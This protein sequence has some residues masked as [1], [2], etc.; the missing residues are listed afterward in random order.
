MWLFRKIPEKQIGLSQISEYFL[1]YLE[2][3]N[4]F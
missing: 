1:G 4:I 2:K 3:I